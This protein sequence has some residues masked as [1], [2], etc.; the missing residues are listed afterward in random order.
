MTAETRTLIEFKDITGVEIE[1]PECHLTVLYP[2]AKVSKIGASCPA[3]TQ[4]W[5]DPLR[6][7]RLTTHPAIDDIQHIAERLQ[8]LTR[9]DR[10]D[11]HVQIRLR[12]NVETV[13]DV[14]HSRGTS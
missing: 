12:I 14:A 5:F 8:R 10:T 11:I 2:V 13:R 6:N 9:D 1:C 7:D 3:C 4:P